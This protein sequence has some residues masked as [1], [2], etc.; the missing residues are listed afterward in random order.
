MTDDPI[1]R[2]TQTMSVAPDG[3]TGLVKVLCRTVIPRDGRDHWECRR[4]L[5]RVD[6]ACGSGAVELLCSAC[7]QL[8]LVTLST[9]GI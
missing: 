2:N 3:S 9:G 7:N 4:V 8:T 5:G 6:S 1:L